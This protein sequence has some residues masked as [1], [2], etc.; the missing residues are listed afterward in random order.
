MALFLWST[1]LI[2]S[3]HGPPTTELWQRY[4]FH[5]FM[6]TC[7]TIGASCNRVQ[8]CTTPLVSGEIRPRCS[9]QG[10][11]FCS[12]CVSLLSVPLFICPS[13][14]PCPLSL[15]LIPCPSLPPCL[16]TSSQIGLPNPVHINQYF[17]PAAFDMRGMHC[18]RWNTL[19]DIINLFLAQAYG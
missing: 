15:F 7:P 17:L 19:G 12:I 6:A 3:L 2:T 11:H 18:V 13:L 5:R 9:F 4:N 10:W 14:F 8:G 1:V 16:P